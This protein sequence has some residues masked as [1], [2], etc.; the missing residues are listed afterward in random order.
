MKSKFFLTALAAIF[1]YGCY[2]TKNIPAVTGFDLKRYLGKWYEIYRL[3]NHFEQGLGNVSAEYT[4]NPDGSCKVINQGVRD[5]QIESVS[6]FVRFA[7][8]EDVGELEVSFF[9]P[10]YGRYRIIKL[11]P[12]YRYSVVTSS[13][14]DY[15]WILSRTP[16]ISDK[17]M[18]D[19]FAF[20]KRYN[21]A[22]DKLISGQ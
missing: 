4:L 6:G 17:D 16:K 3:P 11:A 2:E 12:D 22:V 19:I 13:S 14:M 10:F 7:G 5:G 20:L 21:F 9:R 18:S 8:A 1:F 15:L